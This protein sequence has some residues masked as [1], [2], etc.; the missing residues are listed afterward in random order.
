MNEKKQQEANKQMLNGCTLCV[1]TM[2]QEDQSFDK[3][4]LGQNN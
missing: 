4:L 3:T 1:F 2:R